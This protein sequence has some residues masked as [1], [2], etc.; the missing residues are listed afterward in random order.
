MLK[1]AI[2]SKP[3][4]NDDSAAEARTFA[5][6]ISFMESSAESGTLFF[7]LSSLHD[8]F[9]SRLCNLQVDKSVNK[10]CLKNRIIAHYHGEIQ[11]QSYGK[12]T[13][14]VFNQGIET[15]LKDAL[16]KRNC[17]EEAFSFVNA[18]KYIRSDVFQMPGFSFTVEFTSECQLKSVPP[19]LMCLV[20]MLLHCPNIVRIFKNPKRV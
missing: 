8:L 10:T 7:K 1:A 13:V 12:N 9:V 4:T 20:S 15:L 2:K 16:K 3:N 19:S 17:E 11:E 5:K 14:L 6:L 18:A